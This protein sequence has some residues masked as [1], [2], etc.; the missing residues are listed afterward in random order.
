MKKGR[1]KGD[2]TKAREVKKERGREREG[3]GLNKADR[4]GAIGRM[5]IEVLKTGYEMRIRN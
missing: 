5:L 2:C 4:K 3:G 1:G